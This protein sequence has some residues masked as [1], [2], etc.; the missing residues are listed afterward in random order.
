M[1]SGR[2]P[3]QV[4]E[5]IAARVAA[6]QRVL[7]AEVARLVSGEDWVRFLAFQARLHRYSAGNSQLIVAQH[8]ARF[9]EGLVSCP[10]PSFVA[11]FKTWEALGRRV[12]RGQR[13]YAILAPVRSV[14]HAA[15]DGDG[16]RR[17]LRRGEEPGAG[18]GDG[19]RRW[20]CGAGRWSTCGTPPRPL[21]GR[22]RNRPGP[23]C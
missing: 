15:V 2:T 17:V 6:T 19:V 8:R 12:E 14:A 13:G 16:N 11:G 5:A 21:A 4:R 10:E 9:E 22:C 1:G 18:G 23:S 7:E 3:Q 20:C